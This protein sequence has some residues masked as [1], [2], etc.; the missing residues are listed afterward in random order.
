MHPGTYFADLHAQARALAGA[1][2]FTVTV[3]DAAAGL[4]R[5]AYSSHPVD[6]PVSGTKPLHLDAWSREV[7]V[8][9]KC[10]VANTTAEF[11]PHFFDHALI[12]ALGCHSALNVP[13]ID[14]GEVV[15]TVNFLDVEN[16]FT[17]ARVTALTGLL[18]ARHTGIVAA[19]RAAFPAD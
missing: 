5:R 12:N 1:R 11:A 6:Y 10:F 2:L 8:E 19:M 15:G 17:P 18:S 13:V 16:H 9:G 3:Q 4:V 14:D 7:L